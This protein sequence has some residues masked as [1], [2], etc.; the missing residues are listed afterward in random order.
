MAGSS[1]AGPSTPRSKKN[2]KKR[3]G[4]T[5]SAERV[6]KAARIEEIDDDDE[7]EMSGVTTA[8]PMAALEAA[9][10]RGEGIHDG[11]V[12]E[13]PGLVPGRA[14]IR[15]DEFEQ[16]AEREV[17]ATKTLGGGGDEGKMKLVH[18]VRHQVGGDTSMLMPRSRFPP[19]S[20]TSPSPNISAT[21]PQRGRTSL[22]WIRSSKCRRRVSSVMRASWCLRILRRVRLLSPNSPSPRA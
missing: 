3:A 21:T 20:P 18:Q 4:G 2:Q 6:P 14:P 7:E 16:E 1:S 12:E 11:E 22:S 15:A 8:D 10:E 9:E 13:A 17:D 5:P 19:T